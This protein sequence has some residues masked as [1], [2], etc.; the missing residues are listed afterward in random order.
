MNPEKTKALIKQFQRKQKLTKWKRENEPARLFRIKG[1][2]KVA[3]V[4]F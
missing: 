2:S 1:F 4:G 3:P